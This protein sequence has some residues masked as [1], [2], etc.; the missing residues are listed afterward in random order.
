MVELIDLLD[1]KA[2]RNTDD[3][4]TVRDRD[5]VVDSEEDVLLSRNYMIYTL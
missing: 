3:G 1:G 4:M 5:S 2:V